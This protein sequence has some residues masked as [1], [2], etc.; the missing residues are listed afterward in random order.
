ME[1]TK[2]NQTF[3]L[4][5]TT[6]DGWTVS[7]SAT[8]E[9]DGNTSIN[10]SVS[11]DGELNNQVGYYNYNVPTDGMVNININITAIPENLDAVI[12]YTQTATKKIKDYLANQTI[13][14]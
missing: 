6:S 14:K 4:K 1:I 9:V 11:K 8:Q 12:D 13:S 10:F 3:N 2:Q 5:D 7:G